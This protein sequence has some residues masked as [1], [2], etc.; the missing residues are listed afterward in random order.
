MFIYLWLAYYPM[1]MAK[2]G[3]G[4]GG[5]VMFAESAPNMAMADGAGP[6]RKSEL[7]P[8]THVRKLF[9]ETWLWKS[10][11]TSYVISKFSYFH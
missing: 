3:G 7:A 11:E 8:V 1:P 5:E 9:P 4:F 2:A 6:P 10:L